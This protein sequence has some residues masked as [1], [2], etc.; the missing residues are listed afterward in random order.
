MNYTCVVPN[1]KYMY[2]WYIKSLVLT[3]KDVFTSRLYLYLQEY[4]FYSYCKYY[5]DKVL[6][7]KNEWFSLELTLGLGIH[8][9]LYFRVISPD[10]ISYIFSAAPAKDFGG[11][12]VS[13]FSFCI[14]LIYIAFTREV[15]LLEQKQK[16]TLT[17]STTTSCET[18]PASVYDHWLISYRW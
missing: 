10:D 6:P 11:C 5:D 7:V 4:Y 2:I 12:F 9:L 16:K 13:T 14:C 15:I 18:S 17:T 1:T 3:S 8:E